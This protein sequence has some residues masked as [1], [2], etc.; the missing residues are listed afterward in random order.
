MKLLRAPDP[1]K[2]QSYFLSALTQPQLRR[3]LFPLGD[4]RKSEVRRLAADFRLPNRDRPDSQGLCFL[5]KVKFDEF[6]SAYLGT[7]PGDVVDHATGR[8]VGRHRGLWYHTVGQRKGMG[9]YLD[10]KET[11]RGPWYVVAKDPERNAV[12]VSNRYNEERAFERARTDFRVEDITWI[13]G[14]VPERL[15]RSSSL[16]DD[17]D[18]DNDGVI[19]KRRFV[20]ARFETKIRHG[21]TI[22]G[23]EL[24]LDEDGNGTEGDVSLDERDKGLAPGQF[25]VLY[26]PG[27]NEC[28]GSGIIGERHWDGFRIDAD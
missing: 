4:Y 22:V 23:C 8:T 10:P 9:K 15:L 5:G 13:G 18:D 2:D 27:G 1:V 12:V 20:P 19:S 7:D 28:V 14:K 16:D 11:A 25:C 24:T 26:D 6:L 17:N 21:P 3:L